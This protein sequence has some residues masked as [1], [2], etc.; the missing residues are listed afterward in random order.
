MTGPSQ[1][2]LVRD[3]ALIIAAAAV[4]MALARWNSGPSS[5][6]ILFTVSS[7]FL[8]AV[9]SFKMFRWAARMVRRDPGRR[10]P[11][12]IPG[13][14]TPESVAAVILAIATPVLCL[15]ALWWSLGH[16]HELTYWPSRGWRAIT[17][18]G[19]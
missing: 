7:G 19:R 9:A 8:A 1:K 12:W 16:W 14:L 4:L 5:Q 15:V 13:G 11:S 17:K 6:H 2:I 10:A 18:A 3:L